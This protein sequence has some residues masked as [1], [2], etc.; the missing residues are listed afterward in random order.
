M[1]ENNEQGGAS[2]IGGLPRPWSMAVQ[3]IGTFGLAVFL[4]LYYVFVMQPQE[5]KRYDELRESVESLIQ[6]VEKGQ[7]LLTKDQA[8]RLESLYV[9]AVANELSL[10][11]HEELK[12]ETSGENLENIIR[13]RMLQ[14]TELLEGLAKEGGRSISEPIVHR[15]A[16]P[17]GVSKQIAEVAIREWKI[18]SLRELSNNLE[19]FLEFAFVE[20]RM[21]K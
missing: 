18:D 8:K 2:G 4:V 7:T 13:N 19:D 6:I 16:D 5:R 3:L 14:R 21:A 10:V 12:K 17:S 1:V 9:I 11:I 20:R 15:I